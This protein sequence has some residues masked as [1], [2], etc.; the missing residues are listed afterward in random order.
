MIPRTAWV[1][2]GLLATVAVWGLNLTAVKLLTQVLE[3]SVVALVR[4]VLAVAFLALLLHWREPA[5]APWRGRDLGWGVLIGFLMVY[6][7]QLLVVGGMARTTATNAALV[8]SLGPFLSLLLEA[9]VFGKR[10]IP[11]QLTGAVLAMAGVVMVVLHRPGAQL[12]AAAT[13]DLLVLGSVLTWAA[14][15]AAVQR[16]ARTRSPLAISV[17]SH[18]AGAVLLL[19]HTGVASSGAMAAVLALPPWGWGLVLFSGVVATA[20]G[21]VAWS[22]GIAELGM[23]STATYLSWMPVFAAIF[24][25]VLT[26]EPVTGWHV[27]GMLAVLTGSTLAL[28]TPR[29]P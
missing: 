18:A 20:M 15:G 6:A 14:G 2:L 16:L 21:A 13:G 10:L 29:A 3:L 9:V 11:R 7:Q 17:F 1:H 12:A 4:M 5:R 26:H 27:A 22:R 19:V 24:G 8:M 28:R 23:G 25:A